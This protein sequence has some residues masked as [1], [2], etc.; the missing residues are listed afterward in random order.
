MKKTLTALAIMALFAACS[1]KPNAGTDTNI[2][3]QSDSASMDHNSSTDK[4]T[5][6]TLNGVSDTIVGSDGTKYVKEGIAT[7]AVDQPKKAVAT[8]N[9]STTHHTSHRSSGSSA[10]GNTGVSSTGNGT[11][12]STGTEATAPVAKK[13][14]WSNTLKGTVIGAGT[15]AA[16]GAIISKNSG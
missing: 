12:A 9:R 1:S 8:T 5:A 3:V 6:V 7:P 2:V 14:G 11:S 15:G 13:K 10:T 16:A 4:G